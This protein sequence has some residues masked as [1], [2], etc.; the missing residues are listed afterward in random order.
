MV[1]IL[2]EEILV[3]YWEKITQFRHLYFDKPYTIPI[4]LPL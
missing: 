1:C 4:S 2:L 3:A